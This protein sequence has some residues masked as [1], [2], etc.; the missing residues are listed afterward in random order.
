VT[1]YRTGNHWGITIVRE[2]DDEQDAQL[3]AVVVNGDQALAERICALLNAGQAPS[4]IVTAPGELTQEEFEEFRTAYM[5]A[6]RSAGAS[7]RPIEP[8]SDEQAR[9]EGIGYPE[10]PQ[11]LSERVAARRRSLFNQPHAWTPQCVEVC[12]H[13]KEL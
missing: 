3:V 13:G 12:N 6:Q 4:L 1:T 11:T 9:V 7:G 8:V 2:G 10:P 5:Q